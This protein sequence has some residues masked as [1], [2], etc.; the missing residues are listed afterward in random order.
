MIE[1]LKLFASCVASMRKAEKVYQDDPTP[2]NRRVMEDLQSKV[3]GWLVWINKQDD[4]E[5][6]G[7]LPPFIPHKNTEWERSGLKNDIL[8]ILRKNHSQEEIDNFL[9][10]LYKSI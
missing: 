6:V 4:E 7:N 5:L 2:F 1:S 10:K 9:E 3:D 8:Q